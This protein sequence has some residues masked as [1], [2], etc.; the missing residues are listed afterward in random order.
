MNPDETSRG[1]GSYTELLRR[2]KNWII[3]IVPAVILISVYLAYT[4]PV[5]Y[6]STATII[7]EP[8][9]IPQE[10]IQ[11]TVANYADQQIEIISGRVMASETLKT[12]VQQFDPYPDAT[13]LTLEQK[14]HRILTDMELQRVD[15]VTLEPLEKSPAFSLHYQNPNPQRAALVTQRLAELF[16]TY[17]QR[18]RT[19]AAQ[20]AA[21]LISDRADEL[22]D[23]LRKVDVEYAELRSKHGD[24]LTETKERN[25]VNRDR[26]ERDLEDAQRQLRVAQERQ[27]L[28]AIQLNGVSPNLLA[29]KGGDLTDLATVR[30]QLADAEQ[31]YTPD[32]PDV[33]R[34]RRALASLMAQQNARGPV[35]ATAPAI[36]AD[37][38]EYQRVASQ[39]DSA[40]KDVAALQMTV[41]RALADLS[42]YTEALHGSPEIERQYVELQRRRDSLQT[43]FQQVQEKLKGAEMGQRFEAEKQGEHFSEIRAPFP[44]SSPYYPNRIGLMLLGVVLGGTIAAIAVAIAESSDATMRG[45]RDIAASDDLPLLGGV[46]QILRPNDDRRRKMIWGTVCAAYVAAA[47]L[48]T[49]TVIHAQIRDSSAQSVSSPT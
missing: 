14:A 29:N 44:A 31:R 40:N 35:G 4:L 20:A 39:L 42:R 46:P 3:T 22:T 48:V 18:E 47:I 24:S 25:E 12:L 45:A 11:T 34:L 15:P 27:S 2:R 49:V 13:D 21:K 9:S 16:L 26:A 8:S 1:F 33:K 7:L 30:A 19:Q 38:P 37:N 43:Q 17:H 6:R 10:F 41:Q 32:H 36:K 23:E 5:Q 28:L